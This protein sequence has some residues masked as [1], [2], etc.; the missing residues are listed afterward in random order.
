MSTDILDERTTTAVLAICIQAGFLLCLF[1]N[2][3][4]AGDMLL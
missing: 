1:F 3:E 4:D 2:P